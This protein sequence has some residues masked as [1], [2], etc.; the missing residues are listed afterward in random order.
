MRAAK[1]ATQTIPIVFD[2]T[3]LDPV[4]AGLVDSLA[5]PGGNITG[6]TLSCP[7]LSSKRLELFKEAFPKVSR[8]AVLFGA[9][10]AV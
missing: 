8:S 6:L 5:A 10:R 3:G 7:E 9:S 1:K 2:D 4:A